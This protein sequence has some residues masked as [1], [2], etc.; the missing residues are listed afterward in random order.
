MS[1]N[2]RKSNALSL[3]IAG[4]ADN[5]P[6]RVVVG[7]GMLLLL[8]LLLGVV[9]FL[10]G[11]SVYNF[12]EGQSQRS[13]GNDLAYRSSSTVREQQL[14]RIIELNQE[15]INQLQDENNRRKQDVSDL[16]TRVQELGKSIEALKQL[17]R[18]VES[19]VPSGGGVPTPTPGN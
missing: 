14:S 13:N 12:F 16:E 19:K 8:L 3:T 4:T 9:L 11:L 17:A 5:S 2:R 1:G 15:R 10:A 18:E 7:R 6:S